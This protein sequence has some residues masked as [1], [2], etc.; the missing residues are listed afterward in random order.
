M[1]ETAPEPMPQLLPIPDEFEDE[2]WLEKIQKARQIRDELL[3]SRDSQ[4]PVTVP[5]RRPRTLEE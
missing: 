3:E 2:N 1:K 4:P 5:M